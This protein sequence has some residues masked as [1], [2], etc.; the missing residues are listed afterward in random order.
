MTGA[1]TLV[2][3]GIKVL[4]VAA[5]AELGRAVFYSS[6]SCLFRNA[7]DNHR[8]AALAVR[9]VRQATVPQSTK[10]PR[11]KAS[12][13]LS[14]GTERRKKQIPVAAERRLA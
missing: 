14:L 7:S 12:G 10:A 4:Q 8:I 11:P 13:H 1:A 3:R 9:F 5:A 6:N 2:S